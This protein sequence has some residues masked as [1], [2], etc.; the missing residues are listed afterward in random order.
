MVEAAFREELSGAPVT[1]L[2]RELGRYLRSLF[3][4]FRHE[5]MHAIFLDGRHR[6]IADE[7]VGEGRTGD[8]S[9]SARRLLSRAFE[10]NTVNLIIA[11][12]HPSGACLPSDQDVSSTRRLKDLC[13]A[14]D[15]NLIDHIIV[16]KNSCYSMK[17]GDKF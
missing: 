7:M 10:L 13:A 8:I 17:S 1:G 4:D 12:N 2:S 6:Y 16:T 5:Q 3:G 14:V 9:M 15:L 11:H